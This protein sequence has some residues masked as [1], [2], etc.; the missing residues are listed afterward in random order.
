MS[1]ASRSLYEQL[2]ADI[3][4]DQY[5][6]TMADLQNKYGIP[7]EELEAMRDDPA[8]IEVFEEAQAALPPPRLLDET[9][10]SIAREVV[11]TQGDVASVKRRWGLTDAQF[12]ALQSDASYL[13]Y[14]SGYRND[15]QNAKSSDDLVGAYAR[16]AEEAGAVS[17]AKA[18][19]D[20]GHPLAARASVMAQLHKIRDAHEAK[21]ETQEWLYSYSQ[22]GGTIEHRL[23]LRFQF[24]LDVAR[25]L[26]GKPIKL[27]ITEHG[28]LNSIVE[29]IDADPDADPD[30]VTFGFDARR[31]TKGS[32]KGKSEGDHEQS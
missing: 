4:S 3:L 15:I 6:Y 1:E 8:F 5:Q 29:E 7:L 13:G 16:L 23:G 12:D 20:N 27:S 18:L 17:L 24:P 19:L 30:I 21:Q 22:T 31:G 26:D 28:W 25:R 11:V 2:A 32:S 9:Q 10:R 14:L